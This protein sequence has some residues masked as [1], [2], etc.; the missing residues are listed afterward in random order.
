[1]PPD[2][3]L[4]DLVAGDQRQVAHVCPGHLPALLSQVLEGRVLAA[5]DWKTTQ[6]RWK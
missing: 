5:R 2:L 6:G 4:M 3:L 1:M